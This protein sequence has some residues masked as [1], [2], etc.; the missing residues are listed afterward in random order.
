[1]NNFKLFFIV[2]LFG[3]NHILSQVMENKLANEK[4][5]YLK[6]HATNPVDWFPWS[7]DALE[8]APKI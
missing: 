2:F 3:F 6:Q 7:D 1:M 5:L 4:S 8:T